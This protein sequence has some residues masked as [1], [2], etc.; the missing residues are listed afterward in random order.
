[1]IKKAFRP[2]DAGK[3][4]FH[5]RLAPTT[6]SNT[7][8]KSFVP[9]PAFAH[10]FSASDENSGSNKKKSLKNRSERID[11]KDYCP[12]SVAPGSTSYAA[13]PALPRPRRPPPLRHH[14]L[15]I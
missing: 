6:G 10:Q 14:G 1:M 2:S 5:A 15:D 4:C 11:E 3:F 8:E 7:K 12:L 13:V 9:S